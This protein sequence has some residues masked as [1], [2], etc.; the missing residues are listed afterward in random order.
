MK[1]RRKRDKRK[2]IK[3]FVCLVL[4]LV[5]AVYSAVFTEKIIKPNLAAIAEVKVKSMMTR[6][7]NEAVREQFVSDADVKGLLTIKTDQEGNITYVESNTTAMN[8]LATNLTQ[9]VQNQ[10]KWEDASMLRVPA[11]SIL[12]SQILSQFGPYVT[13]KVLPIGTSKVNFKTEFE[14]MGIN[15]TKYKVYLVM[16]SQARVLAPFSINNIDV[17]NTILIAE[18]IIVGEVPN[19]YIN[20]PPGSAMDA[21]N[22][23]SE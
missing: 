15:Q 1:Q 5:L 12:G 2:S 6:I 20:V 19:S 13:L 21:T 23:F 16:D 18:A 10:Y 14:S 22:F 9:A 3:W 11:G 8:A 17:Q 4:L 7:V